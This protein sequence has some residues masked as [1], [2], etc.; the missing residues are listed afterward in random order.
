MSSRTDFPPTETTAGDVTDDALQRRVRRAEQLLER[1][2][3]HEVASRVAGAAAH[4]LRNHLTGLQGHARLLLEEKPLGDPD[5]DSLLRIHRASEAVSELVGR[6]RTVFGA[7]D[8]GVGELE[9]GE[10]IESTAPIIRTLAGEWVAV[11]L[12]YLESAR[13]EMDAGECRQLLLGLSTH[14]LDRMASGGM[15][16]LSLERDREVA[17]DGRVSR[18][19]VLTVADTGERVSAAELAALLDPLGNDRDPTARFGLGLRTARGIVERAG[20]R[21]SVRS[22]ADGTRVRVDLPLVDRSGAAAKGDSTAAEA[23]GPKHVLVV[24]DDDAV[25]EVA[26]KILRRF[27]YRIDQANGGRPALDLL[28]S[29]PAPPDLLL[30]D[31]VMPGMNGRQLAEEVQSR[32]PDLPV[33]FMSAYTE[34]EVILHGIRVAEV[35]FLP[36]PFTLDGLADAVRKVLAEADAARDGSRGPTG[37]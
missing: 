2:G 30:S 20:G 27:G 22:E 29:M 8:S 19:A 11:D 14:A 3:R 7:A 9:L 24:D 35:N 33:L 6:F 34:D 23:S 28:E 12:D 5:R 31:I 10:A 21:I 17:D 16:H 13:V 36:K 26:V 1:A 4:E 15:L 25:R 37:P 18:W 32:H